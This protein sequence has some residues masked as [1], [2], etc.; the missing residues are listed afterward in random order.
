VDTLS[1]VRHDLP[2]V[3]YYERKTGEIL[4]RYGPGPRVHYH[5]GLFDAPPSPGASIAELRRELV[6]SQEETLRH[7]ARLWDAPSHLSGDV[8]DVGCGLGGGSIFW[9][10]E[11]DAR[12]TA[13]TIAPSHVDL[14]RQFARQAGVELQV[15]VELCDALTLPGEACFDSAV[16]I[17]S[18]V[19]WPRAP[20][21]RRL[22]RLL[23]PG[24]RVFIFDCFLGRP[25]CSEYAEPFNSH[26]CSQI[27]TIEEYAAA[28]EGSGFALTKV[29][30]VSQQAVHFWTR[31][32]AIMSMEAER[33][34]A[35]ASPAARLTQS[36]QNHARLRRGLIDGGLRHAFLSFA[37]R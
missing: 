4:R 36:L 3:A 32:L 31:T 25:E 16:A 13:V 15:R 34:K 5:T 33:G 23:R 7:A 22:A 26:W 6:D 1:N 10:Q 14:I 35:S 21:F 2:A 12:V 9:A 24:G 28:A 27:G 37:R 11:Y 17:D 8:L 19:A 30:D 20:W 18:A 29:E